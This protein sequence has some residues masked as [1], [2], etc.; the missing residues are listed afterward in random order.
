MADTGVIDLNADLVCLGGRDL[1]ILNRQVLT[2]L[3]RDGRLL[4]P[5]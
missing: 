1:D 5:R 2:G 4:S 3:P